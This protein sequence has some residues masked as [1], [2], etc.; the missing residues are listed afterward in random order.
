MQVFK[1]TSL[2]SESK[3]KWINSILQM[4]GKDYEDWKEKEGVIWARTVQFNNGFE[5]DL[6][7]CNGQNNPW[8]EAVLFDKEGHELCCTEPSFNFSLPDESILFDQEGNEYHVSIIKAQTKEGFINEI[9]SLA[10]EGVRELKNKG[11]IK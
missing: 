8:F 1:V 11:L 10:K 7:L 5:V 2:I 4:V 6:K 3:L 9:N